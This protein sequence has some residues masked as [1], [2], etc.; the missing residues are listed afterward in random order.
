ML[1]LQVTEN[2]A[3][4]LDECGILTTYR[5]ETFVKG[6]GYIKTYFVPLDENYNLIKKQDS[7]N[8]YNIGRNQNAN[9]SSYGLN[10]EKAD[11]TSLNSTYGVRDLPNDVAFEANLKNLNFSRRYSSVSIARESIAPRDDLSYSSSEPD[12]IETRC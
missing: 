8:Y 3:V 5:G 12:V 6:R 9:N 7:I 2:T 10:S 4:I 1:S 11:S